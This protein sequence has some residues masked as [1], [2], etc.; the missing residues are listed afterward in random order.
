MSGS[1]SFEL[2]RKLDLGLKNAYQQE[3]RSST[4][5]RKAWRRISQSSLG[6]KLNRIY[7]ASSQC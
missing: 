1:S 7:F 4:L 3:T 6:D 5:L 2:A